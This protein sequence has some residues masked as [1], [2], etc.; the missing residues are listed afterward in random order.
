MPSTSEPAQIVVE[1]L[2]LERDPYFQPSLLTEER[3]A[4]GRKTATRQQGLLK[5]R[6]RGV[7]MLAHQVDKP[8]TKRSTS[9]ICRR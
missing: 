7:R 2:G 6:R 5:P 3:R 1:R 4:A 8:P 9:Y